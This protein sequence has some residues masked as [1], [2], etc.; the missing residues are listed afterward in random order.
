MI[1][2]PLA[3]F[4]SFRPSTRAILFMM[5]M[6]VCFSILETTAK[7]LSRSY[8][9]PMLVWCRYTVHTFLMIILLAPRMGFGLIRTGQPCSRYS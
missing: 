3:R 4:R 1:A 6:V 8:P 7:Y 9:V 2:A 5:V